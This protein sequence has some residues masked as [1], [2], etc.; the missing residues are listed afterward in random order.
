MFFFVYQNSASEELSPA[1]NRLQILTSSIATI[2]S[3]FVQRTDIALFSGPVV[4]KGK[5]RF[6][7]PNK[8]AWKIE[9]PVREGFVLNGNSGY[10]WD[11]TKENRRPF[12]TSSDPLA[13]LISQE[14]LAWITFDQKWLQLKYSIT[15]VQESPLS[16]ALIP[17]NSDARATLSSISI[18]FAESGAVMSVK[19]QEAK[20]NNTTITFENV[21]INSLID[22]KEFN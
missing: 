11:D 19:L 4:S 7:I 21:L 16:L 14:I 15:V 3:D 6:K 5:M 20:G 12:H 22:D 17:K 13:K 8:L 9:E 10:R 1:L 2:Q 18:V